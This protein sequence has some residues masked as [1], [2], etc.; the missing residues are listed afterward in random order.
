LHPASAFA[1]L[2][3]SAIKVDEPPTLPLSSRQYKGSQFR[4]CTTDDR[5]EGQAEEDGGD[6]NQKG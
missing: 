4:I 5:Y 2:K 6:P 1:C 3:L